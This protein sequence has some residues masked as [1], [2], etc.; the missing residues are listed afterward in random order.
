MAVILTCSGVSNTGK[1][2][3]LVAIELMRH[4]GEDNEWVKARDSPAGIDRAISMDDRLIVIEG[5]TDHCALKRL[6]EKGRIPDVHV[7]ATEIGIRK[8]GM[9][10]P[11]YEE[12]NFL[13]CHVKEKIRNEM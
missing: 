7:V 11:K 9:A 8:M 12:I 4:L 10:E 6:K 5:C 2:T 3:T 13:V 1:L